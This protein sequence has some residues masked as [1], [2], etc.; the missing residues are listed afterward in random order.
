MI[1][2]VAYDQGEAQ[3]VAGLDGVH[4]LVQLTVVELGVAHHGEAEGAVVADGLL[5]G[6]DRRGVQLF[7]VLRHVHLPG[8]MVE[9]IRAT[10]ECDRDE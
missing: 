1:G 4:H 2:K 9:S 3:V 5:H 6:Q 10:R 8:M 7:L